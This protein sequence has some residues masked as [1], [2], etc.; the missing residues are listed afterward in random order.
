MAGQVVRHEPPAGSLIIHPAGFDG[1]ANADDNV[2]TLTVAID[3]ARLALAAAEGSERQAQLIARV[4]SYDHIDRRA[5]RHL[6]ALP[7]RA[8]GRLSGDALKRIKE[9]VVAHLDEPIEVAALAG[10]AAR[11]PFHFTRVFTQAFGL[12]PHSYVIHLRLRRANITLRPASRVTQIEPA[13]GGA[14]VRGVQFVNGSGRSETRD[15]DLV[16]DASS[17]SADP[18]IALRRIALCAQPDLRQMQTAVWG[19]G[20][21]CQPVV[22]VGGGFDVPSP[23]SRRRTQRLAPA[24]RSERDRAHPH[25]PPTLSNSNFQPRSLEKSAI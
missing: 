18:D 20:G 21:S 6:S 4:S 17:R 19:I 12:T 14:G 24:L 15:A 7:V 23:S 1:A 3:R 8:R 5:A 11:S 2:D 13:A 10:I 22:S 16:V 9:H 25:P